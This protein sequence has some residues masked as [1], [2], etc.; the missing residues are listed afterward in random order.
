MDSTG[1]N[2]TGQRA[3]TCRVAKWSVWVGI[4]A[5]VP[6]ALIIDGGG[7]GFCLGLPGFVLGVAAIWRIKK[8][9]GL[10]AGYGIAVT[11]ILLNSA[12]F[13]IDLCVIRDHRHT[14]EF[15]R[16]VVCASNMTGLVKA[17][18][19][20]A[21]LN[22]GLIPPPDRWCDS[23]LE[24]D[25]VFPK[26]LVCRSSDAEQ[27]ESSYALNANAAGKKLSELPPDMVLFFETRRGW[28][29]GGGLE[30]LTTGNHE[31]RGCH[32]A[33]V[34]THVEFVPKDGPS[35]LKWVPDENR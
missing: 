33:F 2:E 12:A 17:I 10:L 16:Q 35:E 19:S 5:L 32:V 29:Q 4:I 8:A 28:N 22:D 23:P 3:N 15:A 24:A 1:Q 25:S 26:Q 20:H 7:L 11:G 30:I 34:D 31:G 18:H 21:R 13:C 9:K 27:G 6:T 14:L